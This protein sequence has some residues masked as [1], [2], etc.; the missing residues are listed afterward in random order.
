M[1][2][3]RIFHGPHRAVLAAVLLYAAG[4]VFSNAHAQFNTNITADGT[5]GTRVTPATGNVFNIDGGTIRGGN[6]FHSFG[7]FSVGTGN[8]AN[9]SVANTIQNII[10]R[11]TGG[12]RS[13]IDG[14]LTSTISGT[15]TVSSANLFLLNPAGILFGKNA[16]LNT[17]GSFHATTADYIKL[18]GDGVVYADPAR[19]SALT[20]ATP[21]AFGFLT[22]NPAA[23]DVQT[24]TFSSNT[25]TR[26]LQVP[27]GNTLSLVGGR[28]NVGAPSGQPPA[29]F[30]FAPGGVVNI[31]SVA[32]PGEATLAGGINVDG[33]AKL[34]EIH[35]T[36]GAVIDGKQINIRGGRLEITDATLF[37]GVS[38][39]TRVPGAPAPNGGEVNI[40]VTDD[41]TI[42][43]I[44]P[45]VA[46]PGIQTFA[47]SQ[48]AV[49]QADVPGVNIKA[50]SLSMSGP[51]AIQSSRFG[52]GNPPTVTITADNIE[53]RN[54][55][56]IGMTNSFGGGP[57]P[58]D[59]GTLTIN[60]NNMTLSTDGNSRG[61][62]ATSNFHPAFG[63]A[64]VQGVAIPVALRFAPFLQFPDSASVTI[65]LTGNLTVR[66]NAAI[67]TDSFAFGRAGAININA[68]NMLFVGGGPNTTGVIAAQSELASDS[69]S[70]RLRA[71]GNIDV[72]NGFRISANTFGSGN[73]GIVD[74]SAGGS[75]TLTG[76]NSRILSGTLQVP[77]QDLNLNLFAQKFNGFFQATRGIPIPDYASLRRVLE[78]APAPGDLMQVLAK[79]KQFTSGGNPLVAVTDFTPGDAG[80]IS[81]TTPLLTMNAD[82]RIE[83]STGWDGNAG[84][85][86][87]NVG[88]LFLNDGAAIRSSSGIQRLTGDFSIGAG[89]AGSVTITATGP[90]TISISG[91][92][93]TTG[94]GSSVSTTTLGAGNGGDVVLNSPGTV[95]ISNGG[96]VTADSTGGTGLAG[97]I[98]ISAGDQIAMTDGSVSTRAITSD[99]GN[100]TLN[101]PNLIQLTNSQVTT[102]VESGFGG[103]GNISIDPQALILNNSQILANAFGGPGGNINITADFFVVNSGGRFP[104]SLNGIVD[105]SSALSTPGTVNIEATFT[106]V[107][108]SFFQ[109]PSTPLEATELLR[110]SCAAR[111]AGGKASSLV[112]GGRDGVPLQPGDLLPSPLYV[113][114][115]ADTPSTDNKVTSQE[116]P[117]RFSLFGPRDRSLNQYSLLPNVKC[118]L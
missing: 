95:Q 43:A 107:V 27:V 89:N 67:F 37:P 33:F 6:Q 18:G 114:S 83:T 16:Q 13:Q 14:T 50:G 17:G 78:V 66:G 100:I 12:A 108:G 1:M 8:T 74:V 42:T 82:T 81:I 52:P 25:F 73:G 53:V 61:I 44:S 21:S 62:S 20:S 115:D 39:Q 93:P 96:T 87:A 94:A 59:G 90:N 113:A 65:N 40:N 105:A 51:A 10:S 29:G 85:V 56:S 60:G 48:T 110:A 15:S 97:N 112:I 26:S 79:L 45:A 68:A 98:N 103:G 101:A 99:G 91:R 19:A 111:F 75:I 88:S 32:S 4:G 69:G 34:G 117:T 116:P 58:T 2:T 64:S 55:A 109:L 36:G 54:G 77:D 9:F 23:I 86:L 106:N 46:I 84:A 3:T 72:Q 28:V 7:Q 49:V 5:L 118:A 80:R 22:S 38:F 30:V 41:V 31:A 92:S 70:V 11:V 76:A 24:G 102:S 71:T 35:L 57:F 104:T 47:G 63:Q